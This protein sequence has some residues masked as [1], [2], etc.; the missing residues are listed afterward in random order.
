MFFQFFSYFKILFIS[1][2]TFNFFILYLLPKYLC[3]IYLQ[4]HIKFKRKL[5]LGLKKT[6]LFMYDQNQFNLLDIKN[7]DLQFVGR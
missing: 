2:K 4:Y 6:I 5:L 7:S 3:L 1:Q